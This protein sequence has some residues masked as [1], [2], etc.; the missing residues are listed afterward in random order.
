MTTEPTEQPRPAVTMREI[1][2]ALGHDLTDPTADT[3]PAWLYQRFARFRPGGPENWGDVSSDGRAY[4]A[5]EAAA[6]RRAVARGGFKATV[7]EP[8][9]A[10]DLPVPAVGDRYVHRT[11]ARTVTVTSVWTDD[12]GH[13]AVAYEWRDDKPGTSGSACPLDVFHRTYRPEATK[14]TAADPWPVITALTGWLDDANNRSE[15]ETTLRL[16][17][18]SEEVGEVAQAWIGAMGQNPRKGFTHTV[19]DVT[20]EL[21][22]VIVTAMVALASITD[23][24]GEV[25]GLKLAQISAVRLDDEQQDEPTNADVFTESELYEMDRDAEYAHDAAD[26]AAGGEQA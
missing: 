15:Q 16:F 25:F 9:A 19:A 26:D 21:C 5:H 6:V 2:T 11:E 8:T 4:W 18:L 22:D 3:L 12:D 7:T 10:P 17:K 20:D 24:P 14:P 23:I 1:R 13:T